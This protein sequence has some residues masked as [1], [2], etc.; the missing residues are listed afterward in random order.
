M[1]FFLYLPDDCIARLHCMGMRISHHSS[2]AVL[3]WPT[4]TTWRGLQP[5]SPAHLH[6]HRPRTTYRDRLWGRKRKTLIA[7]IVLYVIIV[8]CPDYKHIL[9]LHAFS[10]K[11]YLMVGPQLWVQPL[12]WPLQWPPDTQGPKQV[13]HFNLINRAIPVYLYVKQ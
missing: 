6:S 1:L 7:L 3:S 13:W 5:V 4:E 12:S 2:W 8:V 9:S 10:F 11:D